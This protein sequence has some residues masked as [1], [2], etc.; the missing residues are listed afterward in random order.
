MGENTPYLGLVSLCYQ[1]RHENEQLRK[2]VAAKSEA[3]SACEREMQSFRR[4]RTFQDDSSHLEKL[5][6]V[7]TER[8]SLMQENSRLRN[9]QFNAPT[10]VSQVDALAHVDAPVHA[11]LPV[12]DSHEDTS[13]RISRLM[14]EVKTCHF[15]QKELERK[16]H[17]KLPPPEQ[18]P[19]HV[20]PA[21]PV[22]ETSSSDSLL[23]VYEEI[24]GWSLVCT[25]SSVQLVPMDSTLATIRLE[26]SPEGILTLLDNLGYDPEAVSALKLT[27]SIPSFMAKTLINS[28][29]RKLLE[30]AE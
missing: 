7:E 11:P 9:A 1:L 3:I 14:D 25:G 19:L 8:L 10:H 2:T 21:G 6:Q 23:R 13:E 27:R 20:E 18:P 12:H 28:D 24:M 30:K 17:E 4:K 5:I 29:L 15:I 22:F 16:L 26:R